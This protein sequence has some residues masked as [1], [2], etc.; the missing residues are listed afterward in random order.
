MGVGAFTKK[1]LG[2]EANLVHWYGGQCQRDRQTMS[3][4]AGVSTFLK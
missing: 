4:P 3:H 2:K 1:V